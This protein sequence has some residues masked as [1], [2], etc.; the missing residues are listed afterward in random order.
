MATQYYN[1]YGTTKWAKLHE[2]DQKFERYC[3]DAYLDD[4]SWKLF[5]RS[6]MQ[7]E[8]REDN[9]GGVYIKLARPVSQIFK[10]K[11]TKKPEVVEFGPVVVK[12]KSGQ[13]ITDLVG[14]GSEVVFNVCVFDTVK[15]KGHRLEEV[16]V[17]NLVE[18]HSNGGKTIDARD[19]V[20]ST[21]NSNNPGS[22]TP[23]EKKSPVSNRRAKAITDDEIPF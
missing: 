22:D 14:N 16:R 5:D 17:L 2:P 6:G 19:F 8:K 7:M 15:G 9:E 4:D 21:D 10:N 20:D 3:V 23:V 1:L 11:D 18:F 12:D 13:V